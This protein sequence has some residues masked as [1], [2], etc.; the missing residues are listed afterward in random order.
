M[1][2]FI[3]RLFGGGRPKGAKDW[4]AQASGRDLVW[5]DHGP[6][7]TQGG[8]SVGDPTDGHGNLIQ[9]GPVE[10][11]QLQV[12]TATDA[13]HPNDTNANALLWLEATGSLPVSKGQEIGFGV[14]AAS[15]ALGDAALQDGFQDFSAHLHDEG[16]GDSF[17]W[18]QPHIQASANFAKWV[19]LPIGD[20]RMFLVSTRR[21][22]G[23]AAVSLYGA[24]GQLSGVLI[25]IMG[26]VGDLRYLDKDLPPRRS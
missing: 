25:D 2:N 5:S 10:A 26:R 4:F 24:D 20:I 16:E 14:D 9:H 23:L 15:F 18:V 6:L 22:G 17:D 3:Q 21:D 8:I 13:A 11:G 7:I 1:A 19:T 12:L